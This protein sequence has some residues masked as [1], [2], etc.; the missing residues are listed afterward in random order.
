PP[1]KPRSRKGPTPKPSVGKDR[2]RQRTAGSVYALL[3]SVLGYA[4]RKKHIS[5]NPCVNV[6]YRG[7]KSRRRADITWSMDQLRSFCRTAL[8]DPLGP[9]YVFA[10]L[11]GLRRGELCALRWEDVDLDAGRVV[12]RR[13]RAVIDW[14][15]VEGEAKS[16]AGEDRPVALGSTAVDLLRRLRQQQAE[17]RLALGAAWVNSG[18]V[19]VTGDGHEWN[20][21]T[22]SKKFGV[23]LAGLDLPRTTLH[24]LRHLSAMLGAEAGET[25][26]QTSRRLGHSKISTT[27]DIY[28][29]VFED[30]AQRAAE[31]RDQLLRLAP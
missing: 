27:A 10:A 2:S 18:R 29:H 22:V 11:T 4:E 30:V 26:L 31:S 8:A 24:G 13:N 16:E 1:L 15:V 25:L 14:R 28:G 5:R 23:F 6:E 19:F 20:P 21:Q 9:L 12:V 3:S 7:A 17:R